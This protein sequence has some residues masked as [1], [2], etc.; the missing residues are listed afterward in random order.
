MRV[1]RYIALFFCLCCLFSRVYAEAIPARILVGTSEVPLAPT[2]VFDGTQVLAPAGV[3]ER[4]GAT[5]DYSNGET[6]ITAASG[7]SGVV[8]P[9]DVDG[10]PMLPM[11]KVMEIV[12][13]EQTWNAKSRTLT[14]LAHLESVEFESDTLKINCSFPVRASV[15]Q[16]NGKLI[17]DVVGAKLVSEAKEVY[18]GAPAVERARLGQLNTTTARVVMDLTKATGYELE[19][20]D[21]AA[22]ILLKVADNLIPVPA[23]SPLPS[24]SAATSASVTVT[25]VSVQTV[26]D[27]SFDVVISTSGRAHTSNDFSVTPPRIVLG[28][29]K[30]RIGE[31]CT[32]TG[33][34]SLVKPEL[35]KTAAGVKLTLALTKPLDYTV[36]T[37]GTAII[38]HVRPLQGS[39]GTL[40][41]KFVVIDPGHGGKQIGASAGGV[42][43]KTVNVRIA[44]DLAAALAKH[45]ARTAFS[46]DTD[47]LIEQSDRARVA[48]DRGA[49]FFIS[50][51]CNSSMV[52]GSATGIET[53][54]HKQ[55]PSPKTMAYLIHDGVCKYTGMCDRLARSDSKLYSIGLGVLRKLSGSG[56]P[57]I[58]LECGYINNSSD[59]AKLLNADHRKK[60]ANGIV[61]GLKAYVEGTTVQ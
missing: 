1:P 60:L 48:I 55:E 44:K 38:V 21:A 8:E 9:I 45:G 39:G 53:Y 40:A 3:L 54:Y 2:P 33:S 24:I 56:I 57:G 41:G 59:R 19:T 23:A 12:G 22:Q 51:H 42:M 61:T 36:E 27:K 25:G 31:S 14:L 30:S 58:L 46:H 7:Q 49:D 11:D 28:M 10:R 37:T 43:E 26:D 29:P 50:I 34:H 15:K 16:W 32:V 17:V 52:P 18:I 13:G 6:K 47:V 4:L 35:I 5:V 20:K